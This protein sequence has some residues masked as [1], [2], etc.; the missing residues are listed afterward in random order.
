M[1]VS[2]SNNHHEDE[3]ARIEIVP[4]IDIM[5]FLLASFMLVSL[6]MTRLK[7]VNVDLPVAGQAVDHTANDD[8]ICINVDKAGVLSLNGKVVAVNELGDELKVRTSVKEVRVII[9]ADELSSHR[10]VMTA[11]D[12][13]RAAGIS[14]IAFATQTP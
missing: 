1:P 3:E 9:A 7:T 12:A 6:Q 4:L 10:D 5:F 8:P 2:L 13:A 14:K 11:L